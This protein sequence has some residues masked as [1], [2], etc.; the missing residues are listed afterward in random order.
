MS[1]GLLFFAVVGLD[2]HAL[3]LGAPIGSGSYES[4]HWAHYGG[5][6]C[7][8]KSCNEKRTASAFLQTEEAMNRLLVSRG[9]DSPHVA[10]FIG[11]CVHDGQRCLVWKACGKRTLEEV[12]ASGAA[13]RRELAACLLG[14]AASDFISSSELPRAVLRSILDGLAHLHAQ[15]IVHRDVKPANLVLDPVARQLVRL[16]PLLLLLL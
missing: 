7:V 8:A 14:S 13:G 1:L 10:P 9:G 16:S 12:L 11:S 5:K 6:L 3:S 4:V 2:G 15:G